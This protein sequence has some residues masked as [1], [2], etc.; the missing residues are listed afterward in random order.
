M[1]VLIRNAKGELM[2]L[3][4]GVPAESQNLRVLSENAVA[5]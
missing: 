2:P 3:S 4:H 5:G 1:E